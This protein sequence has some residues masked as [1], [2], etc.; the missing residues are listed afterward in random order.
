M[1][2]RVNS[3]RRLRWTMGAD[4]DADCVEHVWKLTGATFADDG[5]HLDYA[6]TRCDA[7]MVEGPDEIMGKVGD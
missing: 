3:R 6:C 1:E 7:V 2:L 5:A 4:D